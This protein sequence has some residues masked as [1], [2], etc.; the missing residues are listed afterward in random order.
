M[1]KQLLVTFSAILLLST[2]SLSQASP[3]DDFSSLMAKAGGG[4]S[5][6]Q[7]SLGLIYSKPPGAITATEWAHFNTEMGT[8]GFLLPQELL[9]AL[10]AGIP[11]NAEEAAKWYTKAAEQGLPVAQ[12]EMGRLYRI[13]EGVPESAVEAVKWYTKAAEQ[14][15]ATAQYFLGGMFM[16]GEGVPKNKQ[17]AVK[18]YTK[19]AEQGDAGAMRSLGYLY[20]YS[21]GTVLRFSEDGVRF[22][23]DRADDPEKGLEWYRKAADLGDTTAQF[24]LGTI[25]RDGDGVPKDKVS[26]FNWFT[27]AAEQGDDSAQGLLGDMYAN[28]EGVPKDVIQAYK[29][30]NL[31]AA[32]RA[33]SSEVEE[34][35]REKRD[36]LERSMTREQIAEAQRLSGEWVP[37]PAK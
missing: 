31:S 3:A 26:A 17:E 32:Q 27:K 23:S 30:Y 1:K 15:D 24:V 25:F 16:D 10:N 33:P 22:Y 6:A 34:Y 2:I 4:D 20:Y 9:G 7:F 21:N 18:W 19:A 36:A 12:R 14:G 37:K 35:R 11:A 29:W 13:G 8:V 5:I 28:G